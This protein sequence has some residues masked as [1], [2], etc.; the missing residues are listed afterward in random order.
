MNNIQDVLEGLLNIKET[1]IGRISK[2]K[3]V[4]IDSKMVWKNN[5]FW[6]RN[7]LYDIDHSE[8]YHLQ[9]LESVEQKLSMCV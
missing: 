1:L 9:F 3:V 7:Y 4:D 6:T 5:E 8:S 2:F